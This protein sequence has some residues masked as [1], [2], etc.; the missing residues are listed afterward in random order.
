[1]Y[2][3][4][5]CSLCSPQFPWRSGGGDV[6][7]SGP[8][9]IHNNEDSI[10]ELYRRIGGVLLHHGIDFECVR[11]RIFVTSGLDEPLIVAVK[12][13]DLVKR[14]TAVADVIASIQAQGIIHVAID[15]F[16][17]THRGVAENSNEEM[18]QVTEA[19][20]HIAYETGCS[21]DLIHHSLKTQTG[22]TEAHAGDMNAAR[23][24]SSMIGAV[25]IMY[26]LSAMSKKSADE[27]N[28]PPWQA[29]RLIRLDHGKGN[30][31]ARDPSVRWFELVTV[32]IGNGEVD[33]EQGF[34]NSDTV[35]VPIRWHPPASH[36]LSGAEDDPKDDPREVA[37][38]RVRD[39]VAAAMQTERCPL[40]DFVDLVKRE[41]GV[42]KT[43][44]RDLIKRA[45]PEGATAHAQAN[46]YA[47]D[48]GLERE[49]PSPPGRLFV[50]RTSLSPIAQAA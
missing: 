24:A 37:R 23:G 47:C 30:Y 1:M 21:I 8:V 48:L 10:D 5:V 9:W 3:G 4:W 50:I 34:T 49:L 33:M 31:S 14:T 42:E 26:T 32:D 45:I 36:D 39:L 7:R 13:K 18:E 22:N 25:R 41:F 28:I 43:A 16:V 11:E 35:A 20:R 19:I 44:A 2:V 29:A 38:Q 40:S 15:P 17:S 27:L 6:R 12:E 46:G